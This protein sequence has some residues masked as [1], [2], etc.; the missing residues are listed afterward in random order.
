VG[1]VGAA[2]GKNRRAFF[3]DLQIFSVQPLYSLCQQHDCLMLYE[4]VKFI[5]FRQINFLLSW[6]Y[7]A[8]T[9]MVCPCYSIMQAEF[10]QL[11]PLTIQPLR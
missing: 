5:G 4:R 2:D 3:F 9:E 1:I 8:L 11:Q 10:T 6:L 7:E